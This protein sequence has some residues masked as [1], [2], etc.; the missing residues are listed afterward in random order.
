ML[1]SGDAGLQAS[2][3]V[4]LFLDVADSG[5]QDGQEY[6]AVLH[7]AI[8]PL[9]SSSFMS[10]TARTI[11]YQ[12]PT[13]MYENRIKAIVVAYPSCNKSFASLAAT[14]SHLD[15]I[16]IRLNLSDIE[17]L[18]LNHPVKVR[19]VWTREGDSN[20]TAPVYVYVGWLSPNVNKAY[21]FSVPSKWHALAGSYSYT[22]SIY[23]A[24]SHVVDLP[25]GSA[26]LH[27]GNE[28]YPGLF[29]LHDE[30]PC[31]IGLQDAHAAGSA[32][33]VRVAVEC[34]A[35]YKLRNAKSG[36]CLVDDDD[37]R[38]KLIMGCVLGVGV[39]A[40]SAAIARFVSRNKDK[41]K[42]WLRTIL[43][44]QIMLIIAQLGEVW[45]IAST[46]TTRREYIALTHPSLWAFAPAPGAL[47][48]L[49]TGDAIVFKFAIDRQFCVVAYCVFFPLATVTSLLVLTWNF[50]F[51]L[52][53]FRN[54]RDFSELDFAQGTFEYNKKKL[55]EVQDDLHG[56]YAGLLLVIAEDLPMAIL[57]FI[58]TW[59]MGSTKQD[60]YFDGPFIPFSLAT[61]L[62]MAGKKLS[63]VP[64]LP[65]L[66]AREKEHSLAM[67]T[68]P[69]PAPTSSR[70][71]FQCP[72]PSVRKIGHRHSEAEMATIGTA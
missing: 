63:N 61:S 56:A 62:I 71:L 68:C 54:A 40:A 35:G 44:S 24:V 49:C 8:Y 46:H 15:A 53:K 13:M 22:V 9:N 19:V 21:V 41:T 50:R 36:Q 23:D 1:T 16:E 55:V 29:T 45:D 7:A 67:D 20:S 5:F 12:T 27:K 3:V 32:S 51:M 4:E 25:K 38:A 42:A 59:Q 70:G 48:T 58:F 47:R 6:E 2:S 14:L 11:G 37:S 17:G 28:T 52:K 30:E 72:S 65:A 64:R 39:V 33:T 18:P 43:R 69:P 31:E 34:S 60:A 57:G 10:Q 66:W 26:C